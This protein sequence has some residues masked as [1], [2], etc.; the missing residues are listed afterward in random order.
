MKLVSSCL[1]IY[2]FKTHFIHVT[3]SL[4]IVL[5]KVG[6]DFYLFIK[7]Y[8][9]M[10]LSPFSFLKVLFGKALRYTTDIKK[11]NLYDQL[12]ILLQV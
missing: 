3:F 12:T 11:N 7:R 1:K 10:Q 8:S 4:S 6:K 9:L 5:D 2:F